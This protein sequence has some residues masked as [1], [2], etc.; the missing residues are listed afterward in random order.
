M[1]HITTP[2]PN[3]D[4]R[5]LV[6]L[7]RKRHGWRNED[8]ARKLGV[9]RFAIRNWMTGNPASNLYRPV[10]RIYVDVLRRMMEDQS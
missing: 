7:A 4:F 5:A 3:A 8:I 9:S 10:R 1:P 6:R 2:D